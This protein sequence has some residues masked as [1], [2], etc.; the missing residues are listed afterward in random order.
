[1]ALQNLHF[2]YTIN[3]VTAAFP[4]QINAEMYL[5]LHY[6][7]HPFRADK[8]SANKQSVSSRPAGGTMQSLFGLLPVKRE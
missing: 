3:N 1:M 5:H 6:K 8:Q 4:K 7:N 2:A